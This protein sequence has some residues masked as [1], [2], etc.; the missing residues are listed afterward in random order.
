VYDIRPT[1]TGLLATAGGR[2]GY[3][4]YE[5]KLGEWKVVHSRFRWT[6]MD[7]RS[8]L[9][10]RFAGGP[11]G[12][13]FVF[14]EQLAGGGWERVGSFNED[15]ATRVPMTTPASAARYA[16]KIWFVGRNVGKLHSSG[17]Y[18]FDAKSGDVTIYGPHDGLAFEHA[19]V[20]VARDHALW[21]GA[22]NGLYRITVA[23][24]K[25]GRR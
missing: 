8:G 2:A 16:G 4:L 1:A 24:G 13:S 3:L 23:G 10:W 17:L 20:I 15:P 21:V 6:A 11:R 5:E 19:G 18:S 22:S 9:V 7:P 25:G 14:F 12:A